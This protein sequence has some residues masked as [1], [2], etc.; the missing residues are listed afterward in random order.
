MRATMRARRRSTR[1]RCAGIAR[2]AELL[3]EH[4]ARFDEE[5]PETGATPLNIAAAK[6]RRDVVE[7][8]V[9]RGADRA[10]RS[11]WGVTPLESAVR[12]GHPEVAGVLLAGRSGRPPSAPC[13]ARPP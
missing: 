9:A 7:L 5:S 2:I 8:L 6:G 1:R 3:I 4:G 11:R 13:S 10:K 12:G